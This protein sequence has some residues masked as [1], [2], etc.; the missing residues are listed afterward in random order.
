MFLPAHQVAYAS[1]GEITIPAEFSATCVA[2]TSWST[3]ACITSG[4]YDNDSYRT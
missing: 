1:P 2:G 3:E 4:Q